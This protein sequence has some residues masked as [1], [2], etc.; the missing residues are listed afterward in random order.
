VNTEQIFSALQ[1]ELITFT[2][3]RTPAYLKAVMSAGCY[4]YGAGSYGGRMLALLRTQNIPC[5][6][7]IDRKFISATETIN[8]APALAPDALTSEQA[9]GK[10]LLIG[11]HNHIVNMAEIIAYGRKLGFAEVLWNADLPDALGPEADNYWLTQRQFTLAH[12]AEIRLAA[13]MLRDELSIETMAALLRYRVT[14]DMAAHPHS[15]FMQQ[16]APPGLLQFSGPITFVDGGAYDGDTYKHL[17]D[18]GIAISTWLAFE[19][20]PIN[21]QALVS[22]ARELPIQSVL[23]P[24]GL[25][26]SFMQ[27]EFAANEGTSSHLSTG[28]GSMT[29][30]C[31]ALD[32]VIH[33][34]MPD[35]IKL[36]IEGAEG[37]ALRGMRNT[38]T[39]S[40]PHL[41]IS[42]YHRPEDLWVLPQLLGELAPYA[43]LY[44]RQHSRN[45]FETVLYAVPRG[46]A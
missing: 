20:D 16:Y 15:E 41:A 5:F 39:S 44:L 18:K 2:E 40:Q 46:S 32:D 35:Y 22:F 38:I 25:S 13:A 14:G 8:G 30:P 37:L 4:V 24:C 45:A 23:F 17:Q 3:R 34:P 11:V 1:T 12:F 27:V 21:Y 29:V 26:E 36:D 43:D 10:C 7:I 6:G 33:G 42:A 19:P 28:G 31:V 9:A